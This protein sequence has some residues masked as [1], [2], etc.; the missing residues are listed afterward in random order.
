MFRVKVPTGSKPPGGCRR[1]RCA[2][3]RSV[4]LYLRCR[5]APAGDAVAHPQDRPAIPAF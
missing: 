2:V 5:R 1:A 3:A 4:L